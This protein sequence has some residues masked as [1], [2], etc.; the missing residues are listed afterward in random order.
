MRTTN[1]R[2]ASLEVLVAPSN[3]KSADREHGTCS[4]PMSESRQTVDINGGGYESRL[5][6]GENHRLNED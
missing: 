2:P 5:F 1:P 4:E 3:I 6:I